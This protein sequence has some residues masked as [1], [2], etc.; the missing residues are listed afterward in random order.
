MPLFHPFFIFKLYAR[1]IN[2]K[3][4]LPP[5]IHEK[6]IYQKLKVEVSM[7]MLSSKNIKGAI[8]CGGEKKV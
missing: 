5:D 3:I 1:D 2:K 4:K 6:L 8:L 7:F